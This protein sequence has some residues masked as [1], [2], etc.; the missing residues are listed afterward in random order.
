MGKTFENQ[1]LG[2]AVFRRVNLHHAVFND[3]NLEKAS[4]RNVNLA[5]ASIEDANIM[6]MTIFG[7]RIDELINAELDRRD[8]ERARLR[9]ADP[10]DPTSVRRV[11]DRLEAVRN[12][13]RA[14]LRSALPD[15][16]CKRPA[17]DRWSAIEHTRHLVFA[18]DLYTNRWILRNDEPWTR[19]GLV[20]AFL[21][22]RAAYADVGS[23]PCDDIETVLSA[24]D[25]IHA[26]THAFVQA[27][28]P[29]AL[30]RDTSDIDFGQGT[31][32]GVLQGM[33]LHDLHHIRQAESALSAAKSESS[34]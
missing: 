14:A 3:V 31:V 11:I 34:E 22:E 20:P 12:A 6:G 32:G 25:A 21:A 24:W 19:L 33:A 18:E 27:V 23:E 17:E 29:E 10:H 1:D 8:P 7:L 5:S 28:T 9:M 15:H 2:G 13:F 26:R 4:I 30:C 16:L